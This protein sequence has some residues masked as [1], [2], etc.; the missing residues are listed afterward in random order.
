MPQKLL[1]KSRPTSDKKHRTA[2]VLIRE[3]V[4]FAGLMLRADVLAGL[5][6]AGFQRPSPIQLKAIPLARCGLDLIV[7]AKS[8]TGK[9]CV[10]AVVALESLCVE[11]GAVQVLVLAPTREI[12]VQLWE[13]INTLGSAMT[14][15][16]C[17]PFIG[18]LPLAE[19]VHKLQCCHIVVGTPGRVKQLIEE[20]LMDTSTIRLFVLDEADKLLEENFQESINWIY[21]TLPENKQMVAVSATYPE[22]LAQHLRRYMRNPTFVR[23][24]ITDPALLGIRQYYEAAAY[25]PQKAYDNK[26]KQLTRLLSSVNFHQCLVFSNYQMRAQSL[27]D[28]LN[29]HGWPATY[30][31]GRREQQ[32]RLAAMAQLKTL[33][34]RILVST[35]LTARGID[36]DHVNL[37]VNLDLP[38]DHETYLHRIGRA[39]RFG[40]Y[41]AAV[42]F[43]CVGQELDG[44]RDIAE[45]CDTKILQ[46]PD[47]IP[48]DLAKSSG[49]VYNDDL[50]TT[51]QIFTDDP[52][53]C[54]T[55]LRQDATTNVNRID[56]NS[57]VC[58]DSTQSSVGMLDKLRDIVKFGRRPNRSKGSISYKEAADDFKHFMAAKDGGKKQ[59]NVQCDITQA[60]EG[61]AADVSFLELVENVSNLLETLTHCENSQVTTTGTSCPARPVDSGIVISDRDGDIAEMA[62]SA[63]RPTCYKVGSVFSDAGDTTVAHV[64]PADQDNTRY[65]INGDSLTTFNRAHHQSKSGV[66]S[67]S[68]SGDM[69]NA[70]VECCIGCK[71]QFLA[72]PDGLFPL[73][74][75]PEIGFYTCYECADKTPVTSQMANC[76]VDDGLGAE[77][78]RRLRA[79]DVCVVEDPLSDPDSDLLYQ[80]MSSSSMS[81]QS[82]REW[83]A[84]CDTQP[85]LHHAGDTCCTQCVTSG[86]LPLDPTQGHRKR[87]VHNIQP[88]HHHH[89]G[90]DVTTT[91][92]PF[93]YGKASHLNQSDPNRT[94][95]SDRKFRP[96][97]STLSN[98]GNESETFSEPSSGQSAGEIYRGCCTQKRI[99][100]QQLYAQMCY[101]NYMYHLQCAQ[102]Y[103]DAYRQIEH[104]Q[105][106]MG[107]Y[108]AQKHYIQHMGKF[109]ARR[110]KN[111]QP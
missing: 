38:H 36:A 39:G 70:D 35:D 71:K 19:D 60:I 69:L 61:T 40:T 37:V 48:A 33:Q 24:N 54:E 62:M 27:S 108:T 59:D 30:I 1:C 103:K 41:G 55:Q 90:E 86:H 46:L 80:S 105:H 85:D 82:A 83:E 26:V 51:E 72:L 74:C 96:S 81:E 104:S 56:G 17:Y 4:D 6:R 2:D 18:G 92:I 66:L 31:S 63:D 87:A 89:R 50:V 76:I 110:K 43:V 75:Q 67:A 107:I 13:V 91:Q 10:F 84:S 21:S 34:C 88:G 22:T 111:G 65:N 95:G 102:Y 7:Q 15:L 53:T 3:N 23:L 29:A 28:T 78:V 79:R 25:N 93:Y 47:P 68:D 77:C 32:D 58:T 14:A 8:G 49:F 5:K 101:E 9:T 45:K 106:M 57:S 109:A 97:W 98:Y 73:P 16:R 20:N 64:C 44:L 100:T 11:N 42:S 12:A 99:A 52:Q 94:S